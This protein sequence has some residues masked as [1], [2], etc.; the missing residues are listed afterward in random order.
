MEK[1]RIRFM[2]VSIVALS[3][4]LLT[5]CHSKSGQITQ[6]STINALMGGAYQ[7]QMACGTLLQYG[8]YG[9]GTFDGLDGEMIIL[10]GIIYQVKG[11]GKV[12][13]PSARLTTPFACVVDFKP[14][15]PTDL[16]PCDY[17]Q[18]TKYFDALY[19][20]RHL[21]YAIKIEGNFKQV[22]TRSIPRQNP[23]YNYLVEVAKQQCVFKLKNVNGIIFGFRCPE[24]LKGLNVPGYHL[25]FITRDGTR[26]GHIL[27]FMLKSGKIQS[28]SYNVFKMI[29]PEN[30]KLL[31][32]I[33]LAKDRT[34]EIEQVEK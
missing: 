17:Q 3:L 23:P 14:K 9:I 29:L 5:G 20:D 7:G 33:D 10:D 21:F 8:N 19:P 11:D 1:L 12:Y 25:H 16:K 22:V 13:R 27:S 24:F 18:F 6:V 30:T 2:A 34:R 15:S 26:G 31:K 28:D 32:N 4:L